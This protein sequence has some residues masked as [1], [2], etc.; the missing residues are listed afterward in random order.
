MTIR[1]YESH[2]APEQHIRTKPVWVESSGGVPSV[3]NPDCVP[4]SLSPLLCSTF[5]RIHCSEE[6][7]LI[8]TTLSMTFEKGRNLQNT[9]K[10]HELKYTNISSSCVKS[11]DWNEQA[12]LFRLY[13]SRIQISV[14]RKLAKAWYSFLTQ[15]SWTND[16]WK[17]VEPSFA[18]QFKDHQVLEFLL[19]VLTWRTKDVGVSTI[20]ACY[21]IRFCEIT[22][23]TM[24]KGCKGSRHLEK[25]LR[26]WDGAQRQLRLEID[27][28]SPLG[29]GARIATLAKIITVGAILHFSGESTHTYPSWIMASE[30]QWR[31][32][33]TPRYKFY[34]L[35]LTSPTHADVPEKTISKWKRIDELWKERRQVSP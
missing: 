9:E 28:Q 35:E 27:G 32:S 12:R 15:H 16:W 26:V 8:V 31:S 7:I 30:K 17:S 23:G 5:E 19:E 13:L 33:F 4:D 1:P 34:L 22:E 2:I 25:V 10:E 24:R 6:H 18:T 21:S 20:H 14:Q 29:T 3:L 11:N